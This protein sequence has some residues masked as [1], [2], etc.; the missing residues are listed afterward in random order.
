MVFTEFDTAI[1]ISL[2]IATFPEHGKTTSEL[3]SNA[4]QAL[5]HSKNTG[6]NKSTVWAP[7]IINKKETSQAAVII[8]DESSFNENISAT[9][10][11]CDILKTNIKK[12]SYQKL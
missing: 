12:Q 11:L 9:I 4:D 8:A 3:L 6:R 7:S 5:Y 2:G 10:E 1:T